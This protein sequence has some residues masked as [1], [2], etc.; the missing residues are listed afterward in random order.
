MWPRTGSRALALAALLVVGLPSAARAALAVRAGVDRTELAADE[1]VTLEVRVEADE[2]PTVT[3]PARDFEFQ[4]VGRSSGSSTNVDLGGGAGVRIRRTFTFQ[5]SLAPRRAGALVIPPLQVVAGPASAETAPIPV[6]VLAAGSRTAPPPGPRGGPASPFGGLL[7]PPGGGGGAS[8][9]WRGWEKDLVLQVELDKRE[10]FLGEQVTASVVL[11]SP[12]GVV[13]VGGYQPPL[14]DGFWSEQVET[15][16]SLSFQLRKVNGLPMRAYLY[17]RL[18]LFPTRAGALELGSF[19]LT[20]VVRVGADDPFDPF[21][22]VRKVTRQSAP[23]T[24]TV[25]PL[26]PGAPA[27]FDSVNVGTMTLTAALSEKTVAAGQPVSLKL[28]AQGEGNVKAWSIPAPPRLPGLRAF[29]PTSTDKVAP[30]Q[31]RLAGA[32]SVETVLVPDRPGTLTVPAVRWPVFDPRTG[33]YRVLE[34]AP[35]QLEVLAPGPATPALAASPGQNALGGGLK[36]IRA[37]GALSRRGEPPWQGW[38]FWLLLGAP[39]A[40]FAALAGW[41]R[42]REAHA[43]DGGARRLALA[44][45]AA[46]RRLATASR[47]AAAAEAGPFFAE[48][49]RALTGYCGDKLGRPAV[50]LTREDL[51]RALAEAG[52]HPPALRALAL[53]LDACDAGRY[54]G[55]AGRDQV[56]ALAGRAME[57]LEE[58]HWHAAGG[59]T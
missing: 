31:A 34:T 36:P 9:A 15:P 40:A 35:L 50:G 49:E 25:K 24:I 38:P 30:R 3:L 18:A 33:A 45:R 29:A 57:L 22:D 16:Q 47:L 28:T 39:V 32:R 46:R 42:L 20:L 7:G 2:T 11:L 55:A 43:S 6:T 53:A 51:A 58:A 4:V 5:F 21:P 27:G 48:V 52:A 14:Y 59:A 26:P 19:G 41:D 54:G 44:G 12:V 1:V 8:R 10:V 56:L 23:V 37:G 13:D 17:Q